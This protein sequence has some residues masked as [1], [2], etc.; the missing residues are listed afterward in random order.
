MISLGILKYKEGGADELLGEVQ[1]GS[2][3]KLQAV[4]IHENAHSFLLKQSENRAG[5]NRFDRIN[6]RYRKQQST[7]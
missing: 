1:G 2:F 7:V 4:L 3:H 6:T 5:A